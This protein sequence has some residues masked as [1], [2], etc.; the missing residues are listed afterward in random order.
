MSWEA[1]ENKLLKRIA[2]LEAELSAQQQT[3]A[4]LAAYTDRIAELEAGWD[5]WHGDAVTQMRLR[6]EAEAER[7]V[8]KVEKKLAVDAG[9]MVLD[10]Y[11]KL[12]A[13]RDKLTI[14]NVDLAISTGKRRAELEAERDNLK[15]ELES[16]REEEREANAIQCERIADYAIDI[17]NSIRARSNA[18]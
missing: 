15:E 5:K 11:E 12:K 2:E 17:T 6:V 14:A 18:K 3:A 10:E 1:R 9:A 7:D 4:N 8:L 16:A 13:E